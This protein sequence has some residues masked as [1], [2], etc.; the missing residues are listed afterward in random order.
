MY[1]NQVA[2]L[3]E[4]FSIRQNSSP[5]LEEKRSDETIA[6]LATVACS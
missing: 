5:V 1:H 4:L 3:L 2:R 6:P